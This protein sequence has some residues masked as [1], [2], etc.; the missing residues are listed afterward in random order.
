VGRVR[1]RVAHILERRGLGLRTDVD[2]DTLRRDKPLFVE[3]YGASVLGRITTGPQD[4]WRA[5]RAGDAV[6]DADALPSGRCCAS[7]AGF[8]VHDGDCSR[9]HDRM[10]Q[11]P[12]HPLFWTKA[13]LVPKLRSLIDGCR[14]FLN[15]LSLAESRRALHRNH[16]PVGKSGLTAYLRMPRAAIS[17][18]IYDIN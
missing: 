6:V 1:R 9:A 16:D 3:L 7:V 2:E 13:Q 10:Q 15:R 14:G 12:R 18:K 17:V 4:G 11:D 5:A 8:S